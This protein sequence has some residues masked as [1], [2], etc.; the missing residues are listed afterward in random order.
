MILLSTNILSFIELSSQLIRSSPLS[1][2]FPEHRPLSY[3]VMSLT[4]SS[5]SHV[6]SLSSYVSG[7]GR[8]RKSGYP[9]TTLC[10]SLYYT[11]IKFLTNSQ[12]T[13]GY[14]TFYVMSIQRDLLYD[15]E[16]SLT[17]QHQD[18]TWTFYN[19]ITSRKSPV[20]KVVIQNYKSNRLS[21]LPVKSQSPIKK[22]V[23]HFLYLSRSDLLITVPSEVFPI[24][25]PG[26]SYLEFLVYLL[27]LTKHYFESEWRTSHLSTLFTVTVTVVLTSIRTLVVRWRPTSLR[28]WLWGTRPSQSV[29][30]HPFR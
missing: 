26:E 30:V 29:S 28:H 19:F 20:L 8:P 11:D 21:S 14:Y 25:L 15:H 7:M 13:R 10:P 6:S 1:D 22:P 24:S 16:R 2:S 4:L 5:E 17:I 9:S 18:E 23:K 3:L 12:I 27:Y